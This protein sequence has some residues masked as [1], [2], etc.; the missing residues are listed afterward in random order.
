[1]YVKSGRGENFCQEQTVPLRSE[2]TDT[3]TPCCF[4]SWHTGEGFSLAQRVC[5]EGG[6]TDP[7]RGTAGGSDWSMQRAGGWS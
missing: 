7:L 1:M 6:A 2:Q 3:N 5:D 4:I